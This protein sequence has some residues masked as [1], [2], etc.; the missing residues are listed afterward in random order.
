MADTHKEKQSQHHDDAHEH[1]GIPGYLTIFGILVVGTILTY[2]TSQIDLDWIFAGANTLLALLI[3][4]T[5][6]SFVVLYFMHVKWSSKLIWLTAMAGFF[7][8]AI[9]FAF[10]MQDYLTR[11]SG[12]FTN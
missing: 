8:L 9:M 1:I 2:L 10:T 5:K 12:V 4:F 3:A 7:W 11:G 6:M